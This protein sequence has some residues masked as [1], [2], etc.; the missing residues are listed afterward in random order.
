MD[1]KIEYVRYNRLVN[2]NRSESIINTN[3]NCVFNKCTYDPTNFIIENNNLSNPINTQMGGKQNQI[4]INNVN[5]ESDLDFNS[6]YY[7]DMDMMFHNEFTNNEFT[8]NEFIHNAFTNNELINNDDLIGGAKKGVFTNSATMYILADA[9]DPSLI[10]HYFN[11]LDRLG[12]SLQNQ[13]RI[14]PHISLMEIHINKSNSDHKILIDS[15]GS[16]NPQLLRIMQQQYAAINPQMY[17]IS[18]SGDYEIMGDFMAKVYTSNNSNYITQFRIAFYKYIERL[19]GKGSRKHVTI[20]NKNYYV[21]SYRGKN[22]IAIPDYYHGKGVWKPHLSLVKLDKIQQSNPTLYNTYKQFG[23]NALINALR[24][25][26][27]SLNQLNLSYHFNKL[28]ITV[29]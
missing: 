15:N 26:K 29:V 10:K 12:I 21:Y 5:L 4:Q 7:N 2:F 1:S 25:V 3:Y 20:A 16:L 18:K 6:P 27:G 11:R 13:S 19:L 22:L 17:I 28:R 8:N 9:T 24:G 14:K 23:I